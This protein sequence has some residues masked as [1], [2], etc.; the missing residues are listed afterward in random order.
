MHEMQDFAKYRTRASINPTEAQWIPEIP[1]LALGAVL[2]S[3]ITLI[4]LSYTESESVPDLLEES[5]LVAEQ[6][7]SS[8]VKI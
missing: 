2:G 8:S 3:I 4:A 5:E 1:S 6:I 7:Q